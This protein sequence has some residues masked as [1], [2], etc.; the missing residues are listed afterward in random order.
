[1][2]AR[3]RPG[4]IV[5][6][7]DPFPEDRTLQLRTLKAVGVFR[8]RSDISIE[9][10]AVV[11][12]DGLRI[13][14]GVFLA[15]GMRYQQQARDTVSKW[16]AASRIAN[17][18]APTVLVQDTRSLRQTVGT[19]L[20]YARKTRAALVAVSTHARTRLD[21]FVMGSFAETLLLH[22]DIPL[23]IVN[24][25]VGDLRDVRRLLFPPDFSA[26]SRSAFQAILPVAKRHR[27]TVT[28][29]SQCEYLVPETA[30]QVRS[31]PAYQQ[32][33]ERDVA[34]KRAKGRA[35]AAVAGKR[36]G[37]AKG[38]SGQHP[39]FVPESILAAAKASKASLIAMA[40]Q[41]GT[42]AATVLGSVTR[43]VVRQ[44]RC[45]VWVIHTWQH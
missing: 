2:S 4:R 39:G 29:F 31:V 5:W 23:L 35:W 19:L 36:G 43:Q 38:A 24:P 45:P 44:A 26:G 8:G 21:R 22:A 7:V 9:P 41:S 40:S 10:V 11:S 14:P 32:F 28:L 15:P 12:P 17:V 30:A 42:V 27:T 13:A 6:A 34:A 37:T 18:S 25:S 20:R 16:V 33:F 3:P 1:M